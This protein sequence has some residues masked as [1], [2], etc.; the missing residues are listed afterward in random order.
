MKWRTH[1][2]MVAAVLIA[3]GGRPV[4][5]QH[6]SSAVDRAADMHHAMGM[7]HSM[8]SPAGAVRGKLPTEAT[9]KGVLDTWGRH[10]EWA[11]VPSG[12]SVIRAFLVYPDRATRAPVVLVTSRDQ[13]MSDWVRAVS[14]Q[15]AADGFIA[16]A[17]ALRGNE[18][19]RQ[20][21]AV[22][23]YIGAS[24]PLANGKFASLD[25]SRNPDG[26]TRVDVAADS[27]TQATFT[28]TPQ[29]WSTAV[30]FLNRATDNRPE[31]VPS[32]ADR[33]TTNSDMSAMSMNDVLAMSPRD[34]VAMD[35]A[36]A[37]QQARAKGSGGEPANSDESPMTSKRPDLPASVYMS[38]ATMLHT[39]LKGE[40]VYV[41]VGGVKVRSWV[42]YPAGT[43]K[44]PIV[45]FISGATGMW[46]DFPQAVTDQLAREGF[47]GVAP[48]M[49][50]GQG[51]NGGYFDWHYPHLDEG[52]PPSPQAAAGEPLRRIIAV[53]DAVIKLPRSNGKSATV[54][55]CAGGSLS[56]QAAINIP[57][58]NAAVALYGG[59]PND[60]TLL[61]K[62]KAPV[63]AFQ[64]EFDGRLAVD[65]P[66]VAE[67]M[68]RLGK[69]FH[70]VNYP[71]VT[72]GFLTNQNIAN[73]FQ[74]VVDSWPKTI[75]FLRKNTM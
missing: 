60:D 66:V 35:L 23:D 45:I 69:E 1:A 67:R 61:A 12:T 53:R 43:G 68:T 2:I 34:A 57:D 62:I 21:A 10:R 22:R 36:E 56:W 30:D 47:I 7:P 44:A 59:P 4:V 52:T 51:P 29:T 71:R 24:I 70:Y 50:S 25:L 31:G 55:I 11:E 42:T 6:G 15:V 54:G 63:Y 41:D 28:V 39:T 40:W 74:A 75:A 9:A 17:P 48:D 16:V 27:A 46:E 72:H 8:T 14:D 38:R 49:R 20:A 32:E 19:S 3:A 65:A 64:G 73:N 26:T 13:G 37:Q 33:R 5:G 18:V 58:L